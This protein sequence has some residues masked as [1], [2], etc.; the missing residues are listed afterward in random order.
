M[1]REEELARIYKVLGQGSARRTTVVHGLGGM[2]KTQLV[3][4]YAKQHRNDYSAVFWLNARDEITLKQGFA[5]VTERILREHPSVIY[6]A[7]AVQSRDLDESVRAVKRWLNQPKNTGWLII[8]DNYDN[9]ALDRN[10]EGRPTE[11]VEINDA[12]GDVNST[13]R[14]YDIRPFLPD[15]HHGAILITTRSATVK[16]GDQVALGKLR[17]LKDSLDILSNT[18]NRRDLQNGT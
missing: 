13:A 16:I 17:D 7:N 9:P 3:V 5:A 1:A 15:T 4:A 2:G 18:S 11:K 8:C 14:S 10:R 6:I 12:D